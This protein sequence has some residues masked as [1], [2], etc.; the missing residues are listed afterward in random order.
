MDLV[1]KAQVQFFSLQDTTITAGQLDNQPVI[2]TTQ[3]QE[4][5]SIYHLSYIPPSQ[6]DYVGKPFL[7]IHFNLII[8]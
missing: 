4:R 1:F 5:R 7:F 8:K 6:V 3:L 2:A